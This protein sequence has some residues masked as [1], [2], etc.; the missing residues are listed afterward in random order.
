MLSTNSSVHAGNYYSYG[1]KR[2]LEKLAAMDI[3]VPPEALSFPKQD[4]PD[5]LHHEFSYLEHA[6]MDYFTDRDYDQAQALIHFR[7]PSHEWHVIYVLDEHEDTG[8]ITH[9]MICSSLVK[10]IE[11]VVLW[12]ET[13]GEEVDESSSHLSA[14]SLG[15]P[16]VLRSCCV[17]KKKMGILFRRTSSLMLP[18]RMA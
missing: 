17:G 5:G 2:V 8:D 14:W 3:A 12:C 10:A 9:G 18:S 15:G 16:R 1:V 4:E 7:A 6:V 11:S 13:S